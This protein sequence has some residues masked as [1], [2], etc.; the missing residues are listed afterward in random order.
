MSSTNPKFTR[1]LGNSVLGARI[2]STD[3]QADEEIPRR[4]W[5]ACDMGLDNKIAS[6][7]KE[8]EVY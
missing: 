8:V 4:G 3:H 6:K 5:G 2:I 1:M 7:H